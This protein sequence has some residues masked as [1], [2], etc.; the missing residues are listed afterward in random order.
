MKLIPLTQG[1]SAIV[2]DEDYSEL[3]QHKWCYQPPGYAGRRKKFGHRDYR[4]VYMHREIMGCASVG[5]VVDHVNGNRID[6]RRENLRACDHRDNIKNQK[7]KPGR[8]KGVWRYQGGWRASI[9]A[10]KTKYSLGIFRDQIEAAKAYD[11]AALR[12]HGEFAVLN[13]PQERLAA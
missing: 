4:I 10:N 6:N 13:L 12:L 7:P 1:K 9:T 8:M 11:A 2:S 5:K 3:A